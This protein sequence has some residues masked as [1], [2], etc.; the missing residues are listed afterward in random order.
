MPALSIAYVRLSI[1][2]I[3]DSVQAARASVAINKKGAH[4][5]LSKVLK[6]G[7]DYPGCSISRHGRFNG[8]SA[9][10][11][12]QPHGPLPANHPRSF[13]GTAVQ[14]DTRG[15]LFVPAATAILADAAT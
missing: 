2:L 7:I 6:G 14:S 8:R 3:D 9:R 11:R 10:G 12:R 5:G 15:C 1:L 13:G 4:L